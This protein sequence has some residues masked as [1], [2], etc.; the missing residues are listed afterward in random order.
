M[1]A[2]YKLQVA[3]FPLGESGNI[4]TSFVRS[5]FDVEH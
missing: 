2:G 1:V 5:V 3:G 4:L